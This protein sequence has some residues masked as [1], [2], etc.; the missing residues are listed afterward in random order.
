M[1]KVAR[2]CL[3]LAVLLGIQLAPAQP[4][5]K[6]SFTYE[7]VFSSAPGRG[8]SAGEGGILA[9]LPQITGDVH[10]AADAAEMW[11]ATEARTRYNPET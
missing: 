11:P 10:P 6:K 9:A 3:S 4:P 1:L 7:A 8:A 2:V 5:V